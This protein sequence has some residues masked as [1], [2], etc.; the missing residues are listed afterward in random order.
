MVQINHKC[1]GLGQG[2]ALSNCDAVP[3]AHR[4][5]VNAALYLNANKVAVPID[6]QEG[7]AAERSL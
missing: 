5:K 4:V 3:S 1:D 6:R 7:E 2:A